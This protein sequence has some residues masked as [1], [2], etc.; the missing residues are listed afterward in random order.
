MEDYEIKPAEN[1]QPITKQM[2][3]ERKLLD[4]TLRNNLLNVRYGRRV[5]PLLFK[6]EE[7]ENMLQKGKS[8]QMEQEY[9][10]CDTPIELQNALKYIYRTSRTA[11]EENGANSLFLAL[12]TL[13]WK[14]DAKN[15]KEHHAP[16]LLIPV[17]LIRKG[18]NNG[19]VM[20]GRDEE[21]ILNITL[22]EF[23]KQQ[24][25]IDL[26]T[27]HQLPKNNNGIDVNALFQSI[28]NLI[29]MQEEW[30]VT[31]TTMLGLFSFNKFVMWHDIH[32]NADKLKEHHIVNSLME[33]RMMW[34]EKSTEADAR[35]ADETLEPSHFSIPLDVDSS[36]LE[37]IMESGEGKTFILHGPPGTGKSQTITNMIANALYQGKRVLFVAEKMAALQ[38]VQKRLER[39]GLGPFCLELHSNKITKAHFLSQMRRALY[40]AHIER[41]K[42]YEKVS[43]QLFEYRRELNSY[44][45][46]LHKVQPF[47]YSLY[48]CITHHQA[49]EGEEM[50]IDFK[51]LPFFDHEQIADIRRQLEE[52][53]TVFQITGMPK[54]HPLNGL[55]SPDTTQE[56]SRRL[57]S[58]LEELRAGIMQ[59]ITMEQF[60]RTTPEVEPLLEA[61]QNDIV[62]KNLKYTSADDDTAID[63]AY[64][65]QLQTEWE[66]INRKWFLPKLFGKIKW[67]KQFRN[68]Y[69]KS[70]H[71]IKQAA[72][73][74]QQMTRIT[75]FDK[76]PAGSFID[77]MNRWLEHFNLLRSW[78]QWCMRKHK[79]QDMGL[80]T[81]LER[82]EEQE[83]TGKQTADSL[84]KALF[85]EY[86][87][88]IID[89]DINL[90]IFKGVF[91][92]S[93]IFLYKRR[94]AE[95]QELTK[96][97][98]YTRLASRI[99]T[100]SMEVS[101]ASEMGILKRNIING[102]WGMSIRRIIDQIPTLL[103][104]LCPC[105][106]MSP[107]SVAQ[108]IDFN[109]EK[110]DIIIFDEASQ[111]PTSEAVGTIARGKSLIVVGDPNQM[112][113]TNFFNTS[114]VD[115]EERQYDDLESIL[116]DCISLSIPSRYLTW[117]Y[118]SKHESL[119]TFSN[120]QYYDGKLH[121]FPSLDD[122]Q[123]KVSFVK[124]EGT[125]DK[126]KSRSNLREA[127]AIVAEIIRRL[128][129]PEL[130]E[131]SIGVVAFSMAQQHLIE[132][133][134]M[135]TLE[136]NP[137]L[138]LKALQ[139]E[140][141]IFIKNL[142]NVQ[143]DERDVILFS[144]GYGPDA[145]GKVSMNFGP[146]NN[147][148]GERRLNVAVTRARYE[149]MVFST[150]TSDQIDLNRSKAKGVEGLKKFLAFAEHGNIAL[151][152][153][154]TEEE[155]G[156][157]IA[158]IVAEALRKRGY[159]VDTR[160]GR[161]H[162]KLD[163]AVIHPEKPHEYL[164]GIMC[165][166]KNL[167]NSKTVRDR[168]V[169]QPNMLQS[170]NWK[171]FRVWSVD[172]FDNP[173]N[174]INQILD[175]LNKL[176]ENEKNN[177]ITVTPE[178]TVKEWKTPV[179]SKRLENKPAINT[180]RHPYKVTDM[181]YTLTYNMRT[182][183]QKISDVKRVVKK[184]VENE[185]P[186][187]RYL[188]VKRTIDIL[189]TRTSPSIISLV[190]DAL[191]PYYMDSFSTQEQRIYWLNKEK[192]ANYRNYRYSNLMK[193]DEIAIVDVVNAVRHAVEE[194]ITLPMSE[195]H[196]V[197]TT[198]M[199]FS[200]RKATFDE[201]IDNAVRL[202]IERN[203]LRIE[204]D[205]LMTN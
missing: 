117:H 43:N 95:F 113:P 38:V 129:S 51:K 2:L 135:D 55:E 195:L 82:L 194:N 64:L 65:E 133:I 180:Y 88:L 121:T 105:M 42:N 174:V 50:D 101:S 140:E 111:I 84:L 148:G 96:K 198:L 32:A 9:T 75:Q 114:Q 166:G 83:L 204:N 70:A 60:A 81:V 14:E 102:G 71:D 150:L 11:M 107:I 110:F 160:I 203:I 34:E 24:F 49:I 73:E 79:L 142:E 80:A 124:I 66:R 5:M 125:Y 99:P 72:K 59:R 185:Q 178:V 85:R 169:V 12:G 171:L 8:I 112:P 31:E 91:Y 54:N 77:C 137:M 196:K 193:P 177:E 147:S 18:G 27:L 154:E 138:E 139:C 10:T 36:Q 86:A 100:V 168:E 132:D 172:W 157:N 45:Q 3:W 116:D 94:I 104:R 158:D 152:T 134:L 1:G 90:R 127:E 97:E 33:N 67:K 173:E 151:P 141:P 56:N 93:R 35:Q 23:L 156:P 183:K 163:L 118:R 188:V 123:S 29:A 22:V 115:E 30:E 68:N 13:K 52:L 153:I 78:N 159:Q 176:L 197:I 126:G 103:P 122:R 4:F 44:I 16:I 74:V 6:P 175:E 17:D 189:K 57:K 21:I 191:I 40:A 199:G 89:S 205:V 143:G 120:S 41:G 76:I 136:K 108:F 161:S 7:V 131:L 39:I 179:M 119:I 128:E 130:S 20:R 15:A 145:E 47:G 106:L 181:T 37:A 192:A 149:M 200:R 165:D 109:A 25:K 201:I 162:F 187:T 167:A 87:Q 182:D 202:C 164:L 144:I 46:K 53:D 170:L 26:T 190:D 184:I 92:D 146:L 63:S 19:Y 62:F 155:E 48:D 69:V 28:R 98:L 186:I 61:R 58:L